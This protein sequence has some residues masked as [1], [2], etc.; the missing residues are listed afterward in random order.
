MIR[1]RVF[2]TLDR[3]SPFNRPSTVNL[4][5]KE[6]PK[7]IKEKGSGRSKGVLLFRIF[8]DG[9]VRHR[10]FKAGVCRA[11]WMLRS[12]RSDFCC[13]LWRSR[14]LC[15]KIA[16]LN[17]HICTQL[18]SFNRTSISGWMPKHTRTRVMSADFARTSFPQTMDII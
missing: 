14:V 6:D 5:R 9:Q 16:P 17:F 12:L 2:I 11:V 13:S 15:P 3:V 10:D 8:R 7:S 1:I 18:N 4:G